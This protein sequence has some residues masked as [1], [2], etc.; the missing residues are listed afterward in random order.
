M[1][2]AARLLATLG[3]LRPVRFLLYCAALGP[4]RRRASE[5]LEG[6]IN[7]ARLILR[8]RDG[9][10]GERF[11]NVFRFAKN[12]FQYRFP[13]PT[14]LGG[15]LPS[16]SSPPSRPPLANSTIYTR[17]FYTRARVC[18]S[19]ACR[20]SPR[21][22]FV[23]KRACSPSCGSLCNWAPTSACCTLQ[24]LVSEALGEPASASS[25]SQRGS[26]PTCALAARLA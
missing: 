4:I 12:V 11:K 20:P 8:P 17:L 10:S 6:Y 2:F 24:S 7:D 26:A 16:P 14:G 22:A 19:G 21:A 15:N 13:H 9:D 25:G 1:F 18:P 23:P 5:R 3:S